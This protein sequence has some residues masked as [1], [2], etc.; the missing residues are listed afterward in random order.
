MFDLSTTSLLEY[1]LAF[2]LCF[3]C[4]FVNGEIPKCS[5]NRGCTMKSVT[6]ETEFEIVEDEAFAAVGNNPTFRW[7][8]FVLTD[9]LPNLNKN[10]IPES[11]FDNLIRTGIYAPIKMAATEIKDGHEKSIPL[12]TITSLKR[13]GNTVK[14]LAA[15][16]SLERS[17]DVD[18]VKKAYDSGKPLNLSWEILYKSVEDE[19]DGVTALKDTV[20]R[21]TTLVGLPAYAGRTPIL[22]VA[23]VENENVENPIEE[24][25]E[26]DLELEELKQEHETLLAKYAELETNFTTLSTEK[27]ELL[28]YKKDIEDKEALVAKFEAIKQKFVEAGLTRE[29]EYF[30]ENKER[31]LA[32][33]EDALD[34][35]LQDLVAFGT[36]SQEVASTKLPVI[37]EKNKEKLTP[38]EL[39][40]KLRE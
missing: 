36:K 12:G 31:L 39:A 27:E 33:A 30:V 5:I 15:L 32:L 26:G 25:M 17:E 29:E 4:N 21:A 13:D 1:L 3:Y 14:G 18:L 11:E 40:K 37:P 9:D 22:Q 38:S 6:F 2:Y 8:R 23:S 20:L 24:N 35:M 16:W 34:F 28:Q 19:P 10:R 7:C